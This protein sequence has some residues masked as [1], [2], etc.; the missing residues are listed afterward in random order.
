MKT[1]VAILLLALAAGTST[2]QIE[3]VKPLR[4]S[5]SSINKTVSNTIEI[6]PPPSS[7]TAA[8]IKGRKY[9]GTLLSCNIHFMEESTATEIEGG[10]LHTMTITSQGAYSI[11]V[12]I[13]DLNLHEGCELFLYNNEKTDILGALTSDN[14]ASP[15]RTRQIQGDTINIELFVPQGVQQSDFEITSICY[16]YANAF[17]KLSKSTQFNASCDIEI[18]INCDEGQ[19]FQD[20]KHAT[21]LLTIDEGFSSQLCTGTIVNNVNCDQ[22]PYILTAAHCVSDQSAAQN[23]VVYFNYETLTCT[24]KREPT[25]YYSMS[26]ATIAATSPKAAYSDQHGRTSSTQYP[27][28]DFTLLKLKKQ[29]PEAYQPYYAGLSIS[30]TDNLSSVA[31]IHHP[32]GDVKKISIS[33]SKPYQDSYPEEDKDVHYK[34]FVHWHVPQWDVGT[35]EGGSS[36]ASLL[37]GK[38]QVIGILSG[39]YADC[40]EPI[41]DFF[42]ML[43]K[44]WNSYQQADNQLLSPLALGTHVQEILP[45][46]PHNIGEKYLPAIVSAQPNA[47]SSIVQLSWVTMQKPKSLTFTED[48]DNM[49]SDNDIEDTFI[50]NVD[51]DGDR[52]AWSI[53]TDTDAHSGNVC[54]KSVTTTKSGRFNSN[55][56]TND[57]LTLPKLSIHTNDTLKFWAKSEGGVSSLKISQNTSPSRYKLITGL[58]IDSIWTEY[59]IP[60]DAYA[61]TSIYINISHTTEKDSSMAV[62]ID[63]II[64]DNGDDNETAPEISGYEVYCNDELIQ[65]ITDTTTRT[66]EHHTERGKTYTYYVLNKYDDATSSIGNSVV[67]DINDTP[68][69]TPTPTS[70]QIADR[71]PLAAYPNPTTGAIRITA[72]HNINNS[73]IVVADM[74]GRKAMSQKVSNISKGETFE[75]SLAAL[76]PGIYIIRLDGQSIKIQKQ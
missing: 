60:L 27:V 75:I 32:Q 11:G 70:E 76:R 21:V 51:M 65:A 31:V 44:A 47:D 59:K 50:A 16:D 43:S 58:E 30:E 69:S 46:N 67:I 12:R 56:S 49:Q 34:N 26:G 62:Y 38:K 2:A 4:S 45:Y 1:F 20:I 18:G 10:T 71:T 13:D 7:K 54:I 61:N 19:A 39:G 66:F 55:T 53:T 37:N 22:T 23:T 15:F 25:D 63:D 35:T 64:I 72:S 29:I 74:T 28:M 17:G 48:F 6:A 14:N 52:S 9:Y 41:D 3:R 24:A 73:E 8:S 5:L 42:Q 57:Y 33:H 40:E 36:G 68:I